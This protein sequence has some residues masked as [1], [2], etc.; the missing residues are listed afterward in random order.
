MLPP[1]YSLGGV[2]LSLKPFLWTCM[3]ILLVYKLAFQMNFT[4]MLDKE[5][6]LSST[7]AFWHSC[8]NIV[9]SFLDERVSLLYA[10]AN[11]FEANDICYNYMVWGLEWSTC[12]LRV[13]N[14]RL[15]CYSRRSWETIQTS[16][17]EFWKENKHKVM[18]IS[19]F[20][21]QENLH[22]WYIIQTTDWTRTIVIVLPPCSAGL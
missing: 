16:S 20:T 17:Y 21:S 19:A 12:K 2:Y 11:G 8:D 6:P 15:L 14:T 10:K 22:H 1:V 7:V 5:M 9:T 4:S 3:Q 13:R 18:R